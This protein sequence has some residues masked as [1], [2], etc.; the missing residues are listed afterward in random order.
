MIS[1]DFN[2]EK[3]LN[4][5]LY[6]VERLQRRDLHKVFKI[7]YFSDREY[8]AN[9]GYP[10]TCARYVAIQARPVPS[11]VYDIVRMVR[12]DSYFQDT[13][14]IKEYFTIEDWK[15]IKPA[16]AAN[17][18]KI[19]PAEIEAIDKCLDQYGNLSYQRVKEKSEEEAGERTARDN[20][21]TVEAI[22]R[23]GG[24]STEDLEYV[25]EMSNRST[26]EVC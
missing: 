6:I 21:I 24:L 16:K 22:A 23:E 1:F 17:L 20:S 3:T 18:R 7:L 5:I 4:V 9:Y 14:N 11:K 19:A 2:K 26:C 12:G 25:A 8:L 10:I 13:E 15:Y